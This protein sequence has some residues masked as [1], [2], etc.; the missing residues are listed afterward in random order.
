MDQLV[1]AVDGSPH[2]AKV[3]DFAIQLAKAIPAAIV[4]V[5][6]IPNPQVPSGYLEYTKVEGLDPAGYYEQVSQVIVDSMGARLKKAGLRY[7]IS[8]STGHPASFILDVAKRKK[9]SMIIVGVFGLHH[10]GRIRSLGS[11]SRRVAENSSVPVVL[12]P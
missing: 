3:V 12:V 9:A 1:V 6:V 8:T 11:V 7:E 4:L 2:S 10:L 5:N